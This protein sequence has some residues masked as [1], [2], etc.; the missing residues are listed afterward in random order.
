MADDTTINALRNGMG[1]SNASTPTRQRN[2]AIGRDEFLTLLVTQL[3]NQDPMNPMENQEFAVQL[4]QFTQL[5]TL[6]NIEEKIVPDTSSNM[7]SLAAYLGNEV[8]I[9]GNTVHVE[10]GEGGLL[11]L[12]LPK[13]AEALTIQLLN[14]NG[15]VKESIE[16]GEV[17]SGKHTVVLAELAAANGEYQVK[18]SARD[19]H[20][21]VFYPET[22]VAGIVSGFTPGPEPTLMIGGR[23][24]S[25]NQI[26]AVNIPPQL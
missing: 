9:S 4:A 23:E 7:L 13:D 1:A 2:D 5:E 12:D 20:G 26:L 25:P 6:M 16:L 11:K 21:V 19:P 10:N 14:A 15:V 18:V 22:A 3:K 24:V 17:A 8:T